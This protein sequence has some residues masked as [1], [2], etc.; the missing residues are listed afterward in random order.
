MCGGSA[1]GP[2]LPIYLVVCLRAFDART[3]TRR[4]FD[5]LIGLSFNVDSSLTLFRDAT[6]LFEL[7]F[8]YH[9]FP[10]LHFP[11][12][13]FDIFYMRNTRYSS[14]GRPRSPLLVHPPFP[15]FAWVMTAQA[16]PPTHAYA[17]GYVQNAHAQTRALTQTQ[18]QTHLPA[19]CAAPQ[20]CYWPNPHSAKPLLSSPPPPASAPVKVSPAAPHEFLETV[21][22]RYH[23][24]PTRPYVPWRAALT[25]EKD[26][27]Q[28]VTEFPVPAAS[29]S[30]AKRKRLD[31]LVRALRRACGLDKGTRPGRRA[32]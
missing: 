24:P 29:P 6:L 28:M 26:R 22:Y 21:D 12:Y 27:I 3:R 5:A 20:G 23:D 10:S 13:L 31:S 16:N 8:F 25:P 15:S 9:R 30:R 17:Y 11:T 7:S 4:L 1:G 14:H 18:V 32:A 2:C 19:S